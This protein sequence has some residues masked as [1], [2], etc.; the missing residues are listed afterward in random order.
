MKMNE[1]ELMVDLARFLVSD[2]DGF[3]TAGR[4]YGDDGHPQTRGEMEE[5]ARLVYSQEDGWDLSCPCHGRIH[6]LWPHAWSVTGFEIDEYVW[7][8]GGQDSVDVAQVILNKRIEELNAK[9]MELAKDLE[10]NAFEIVRLLCGDQEVMQ[11]LSDALER[12]YSG[13]SIPV[14]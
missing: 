10:A 2:L 6:V 8:G 9:V 14:D 13:E 1:R 5:A 4:D 11:M 3:W 12:V 7:G